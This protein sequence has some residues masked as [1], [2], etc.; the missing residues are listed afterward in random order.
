MSSDGTNPGTCIKC[1]CHAHSEVDC[2]P[3]TGQCRVSRSVMYAFEILFLLDQYFSVCIVRIV[4]I[5]VK[6]FGVNSVRVVSMETPPME[7]RQTVSRA[8]VR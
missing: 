4:A 1:N 8:L 2:D 5:T 6:G 3:Y 7:L